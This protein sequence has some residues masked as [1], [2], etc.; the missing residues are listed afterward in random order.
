MYF[1]ALG[2]SVSERY[3]VYLLHRVLFEIDLLP[4][5]ESQL[6]LSVSKI[7]GFATIAAGAQGAPYAGH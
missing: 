1:S 2:L 5:Y 7:S 3:H 4:G 6:F